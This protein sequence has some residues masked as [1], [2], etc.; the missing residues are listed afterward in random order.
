MSDKFLFNTKLLIDGDEY[1]VVAV[2]VKLT[3]NAIPE[4]EL[5]VVPPGSPLSL[6]TIEDFIRINSEIQ[7]KK[8]K[9]DVSVFFSLSIDTEESLSRGTPLSTF[10]LQSW[11]IVDSGVTNISANGSAGVHIVLQHPMYR[12][13][14]IPITMGSEYS[15]AANK[16]DKTGSNVLETVIKGMTRY[17]DTHDP[18]KVTAEDDVTLETTKLEDQVLGLDRKRVAELRKQLDELDDLVLWDDDVT[19][20]FS[21]DSDFADYL[22]VQLMQPSRYGDGTIYRSFLE[23]LIPMFLGLSGTF[24]DDR[25]RVFRRNPWAEP[26]YFI[27]YD[28][29]SRMDMP[30]IETPI[31]GVVILGQALKGALVG[32][33][34][35]HHIDRLKGVDLS[36]TAALAGFFEYVDVLDGEMVYTSA[37]R[38]L[39]DYQ[40]WSTSNA[41]KD[42][43]LV[44]TTSPSKT[45]ALSKLSSDHEDKY[46]DVLNRYAEDTFY[47]RLYKNTVAKLTTRLMLTPYF[48]ESV[49]LFGIHVGGSPGEPLAPGTVLGVIGSDDELIFRFYVTHVMHVLDVR[50]GQ[51][52]TTIA[53]THATGPDGVV[54]P[55]EVPVKFGS[56]EVG[57]ARKT[58]VKSR[59][60][61]VYDKNAN[62]ETS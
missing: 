11:V 57:S 9:K 31:E 29:V 49:S 14:R 18:D 27:R 34:G 42:N 47:D 8:G 48:S 43:N 13:N 23:T 19:Y 39:M 10:V 30:P 58:I 4:M 32:T 33:Q 28:D 61:V 26:G 37:P 2:S 38:W 25:I 5:Q 41:N 56:W 36:R 6:V 12:L 40:L 54:T 52:Y 44:T 17:L 21:E 59:D 50:N 55:T 53:G 24:S 51:A 1:P 62:K 45:N 20:P 22:K 7:T 3:D 35:K 16:D 46:T 60:L 15:T